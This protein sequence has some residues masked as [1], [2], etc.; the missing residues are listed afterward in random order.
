[1]IDPDRRSKKSHQWQCGERGLHAWQGVRDGRSVG[2]GRDDIVR[3]CMI[4]RSSAGG[5]ASALLWN[6]WFS[7]RRAERHRESSRP[8]TRRRPIHPRRLVRVVRV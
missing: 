4:D 2:M 5:L 3:W 7:D 1:M 8:A 6:S